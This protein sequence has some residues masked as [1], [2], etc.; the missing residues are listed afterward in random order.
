MRNFL[1]NGLILI[2]IAV[3]AIAVFALA[4]FASAAPADKDVAVVDIPDKAKLVKA[5]LLG[6]YIFI[7]DDSKMATGEACLYVYRYGVDPNGKP[8]ARADNLVVS[9]HCV[10]I[11]RPKASQTVLTYGMTDNGSLELREIQFTGSL[12]GHRVP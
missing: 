1:V 5:E 3:F 7:H 12:K 8:D 6:K 11:D 2:V 10:P 9:F 4:T